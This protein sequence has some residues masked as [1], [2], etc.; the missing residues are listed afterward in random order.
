[1][2]QSTLSENLQLKEQN[3]FLRNLISTNSYNPSYSSFIDTTPLKK[4]RRHSETQV[5]IDINTSPSNT[6]SISHKSRKMKAISF[7]VEKQL[8]PHRSCFFGTARSSVITKN[9]SYSA[10]PEWVS[11]TRRSSRLLAKEQLLMTPPA[12][13]GSTKSQ[14]ELLVLEKN[15]DRNN[16]NEHL[17]TPEFIR[18]I[19]PRHA[20]R[21]LDAI[22]QAIDQ[23]E[24]G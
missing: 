14:Q 10:P 20:K 4:Q 23:L 5:D 8:S 17:T 24:K 9:L 2:L 21:S 6:P 16:L 1:M 11:P 12:S 15:Y 7:D 3:N 19:P 13:G 18:S 22:I